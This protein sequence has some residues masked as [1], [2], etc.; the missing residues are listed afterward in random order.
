MLRALLADR[1]RV[2]A[3]GF[4][5]TLPVPPALCRN[6]VDCL[7]AA[8]SSP[9]RTATLIAGDPALSSLL[10]KVASSAPVWPP[11]PDTTVER[12]WWFM[13]MEILGELTLGNC[14]GIASPALFH[15][16]AALAAWPAH[17]LEVGTLAKKIAIAQKLPD[18]IV[19]QSLVAGLLHDLGEL[20]LASNPSAIMGARRPAAGLPADAMDAEPG[21]ALIGAYLL[22]LWGFPQVILEAVAWHHRPERQERGDFGLSHVLYLADLLVSHPGASTPE[23][24]RLGPEFTSRWDFELRWEMLA[25]A[26]GWGK[27]PG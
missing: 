1:E 16:G 2:F 24:L 12:A 3:P 10:V 4:L 22:A 8:H 6:L 14:L 27:D 17:S 25:R 19:E 26:A 23:A 11:G 7:T 15:D 20:V 5:E 13:G 21:H 9:Q 18:A